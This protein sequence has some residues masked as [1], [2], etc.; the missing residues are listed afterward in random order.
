VELKF[1]QLSAFVA[2]AEQRSFRKAAT[3]LGIAAPALS[4]AIRSLEEQF[5]V[6]L[7]NRATR[8]VALT[9]AGEQLFGS[10]RLRPCAGS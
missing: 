5:G 4:D 2:V 6:R 7:L 8:S 10:G 9:E 1:A 3:H